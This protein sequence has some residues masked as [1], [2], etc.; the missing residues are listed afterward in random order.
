MSGFV[1]LKMQRSTF[2]ILVAIVIIQP[3]FFTRFMRW[4]RGRDRINELSKSLSL[5]SNLLIR[6][7]NKSATRA[8][9]LFVIDVSSKMLD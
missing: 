6:C 9:K 7:C 5:I 4:Q 3:R 1:I 8:E 2:A